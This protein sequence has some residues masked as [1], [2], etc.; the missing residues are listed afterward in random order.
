MIVPLGAR[1]RTLG[2][3]TLVSAES[4]RHYTRED[5][6]LAAELAGHAGL[7]VDNAALY[8]REHEAAVTLQ[9]ALLPPRLPSPRGV[10]I[11]A[12]YL[13]AGHGV[14]VG[15]DWYDLIETGDGKLT[16]MVGD[17]AG[18]GLAAATIM[19]RLRTALRAYVL[20]GYGP[21]AA[22]ERLDALMADFD[23]R[24]MATLVHLSLDPVAGTFEYVRAGHPPPLVRDPAHEVHQL[25][26]RGSPPLGVVSDPV[27][28]AN[29][30]EVEP[31]S[32]LLLYTDGLIERR[33][34]GIAPG[35]DRLRRA[36]ADAP[37][38]AEGCAHAVIDELAAPT[39]PDDVALVALRFVGV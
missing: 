35:L 16:V 13:P 17:V 36:L 30:V 37:E 39:P 9:R 32:V 18:R 3:M 7:A 8:R 14:E 28:S 1:G 6:D 20:E 5:L 4:G 34:E 27:F 19:G 31:G 26:G 33:R 11:A 15:G 2:A 23:E 10:D 12:S 21:A 22:V 25:G 38:S 29:P 24:T